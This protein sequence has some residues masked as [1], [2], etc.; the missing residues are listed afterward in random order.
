[1]YDA[2]LPTINIIWMVANV[3]LIVLVVYYIMGKWIA[4]SVAL[5]LIWVYW[6]TLY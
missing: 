2:A 6:R 1:M 3:T 5:V 4:V